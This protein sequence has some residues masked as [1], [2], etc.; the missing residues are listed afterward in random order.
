MFSDVI[1]ERETERGT[2]GERE[3]FGVGGKESWQ[4]LGSNFDRISLCLYPRSLFTD[5]RQ[6][7]KCI[8]FT[9]A[10]SIPL[11]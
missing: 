9:R 8:V 6:N 7:R 1:G 10:L 11:I 4:K 2:E 5:S 3:D